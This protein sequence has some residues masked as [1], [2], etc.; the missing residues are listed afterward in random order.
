M[1]FD[2]LQMWRM[3]TQLLIGIVACLGV[4]VVFLLVF[5]TVLRTWLFAK[6]QRK[7]ERRFRSEKLDA[8]GK[9]LPPSARGLCDRC[10]ALGD[11]YHLESGGKLCKKCF[12]APSNP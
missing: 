12:E 7:S 2:K 4:G 10:G 8:A 5:W 1:D 3:N 6:G 9:K 11:V